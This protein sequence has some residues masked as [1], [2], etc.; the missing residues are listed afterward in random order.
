ML[1]LK[2]SWKFKQTVISRPQSQW[3]NSSFLLIHSSSRRSCAPQVPKSWAAMQIPAPHHPWVSSAPS[4]LLSPGAGGTHRQSCP[5]Q[6]SAG[7]L[8]SANMSKDS[9]LGRFCIFCAILLQKGQWELCQ[10]CLTEELLHLCA[11]CK[12]FLTK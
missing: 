10:H 4:P 2:I 11:V 12:Q 5:I 7:L 1:P 3:F 9:Y 6:H 8:A